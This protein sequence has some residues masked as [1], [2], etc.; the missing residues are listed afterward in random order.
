MSLTYTDISSVSIS[1]EEGFRISTVNSVIRRLIENDQSFF[2]GGASPGVWERRWYN[3]AGNSSLYYKKGDAVWINT[4]QADDFVAAHAA[5]LQMYAQGR[6][7]TRYRLLSLSAAQDVGGIYGLF[8]EMALGLGDF[9]GEEIY[10][11]GNLLEPVQI[12]V[13]LSDDNDRP[14]SDNA[15]WADFFDRSKN[16]AYYGNL[17]LS[18]AEEQLQAVYEKHLKEYH[19]SGL[20]DPR[21][22]YSEYLKSD[23][24][25][26][27]KFQKFVNHAWY[28]PDM[29]GF[30][31]VLRFVV[32][33]LGNGQRQWF[34]I[35]KSG[36]LEHGGMVV[37]AGGASDC[38]TNDYQARLYSVNLAWPYDGKTAPVYDFPTAGIGGFYSQ[39]S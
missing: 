36:L 2:N 32:K 25:N 11:L 8:K 18:A 5:D 34:R 16:E 24:A 20:S 28:Q 33:D 15:Y 19:L 14:P 29:E 9:A 38:G 12:R 4:E 10:Y 1:R 21:K 17:I 39:D 13:S 35:W 3:D 30:D 7:D 23:L 22:F 27:S 31:H 26:I 37:V 6:S